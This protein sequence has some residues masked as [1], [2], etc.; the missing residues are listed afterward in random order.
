MSTE[1]AP[2]ASGSSGGGERAEH[3]QQDERDDRKAEGLGRL[4]VAPWRRPAARPQRPLADEVRRHRR[5]PSRAA[6]RCRAPCAGRRRRRPPSIVDVDAAAGRS[7]VRAGAARCA[8]AQ[9]RRATATWS[10]RAAP[11]A[12][13][14]APR[15]GRRASRPPSRSARRRASRAGR[16]R[17]R[18]RVRPGRR[19]TASPARRS[20]RRSG[21]P[22]GAPRTAA[23]RGRRRAHAASTTRR[24]R[25]STP[26][27][28]SMSACM[29][30]PSCHRLGWLASQ[31][32]VR[33]ARSRTNRRARSR[34]KIPPRPLDGGPGAWRP[35]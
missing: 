29:G 19:R 1:T 31:G 14:A 35:G 16:R 9:R 32:A 25:R 12:V 28:E 20:R 21:S 7:T 10:T 22:T 6:G 8:P 2:S 15:A 30:A 24:W 33:R 11:R 17:S 4:Q 5:P 27:S 18:V 13:A 26:S 23:R 34:T 3:R